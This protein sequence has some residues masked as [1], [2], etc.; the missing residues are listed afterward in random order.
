[1]NSEGKKTDLSIFSSSRS[2]LARH[3]ICYVKIYFNQDKNADKTNG[4]ASGQTRSKGLH[5]RSINRTRKHIILYQQTSNPASSCNSWPKLFGNAV[6]EYDKFLH[7]G[8]AIGSHRAPFSASNV[9]TSV[10]APNTNNATRRLMYC[11]V[12][13]FL[14]FTVFTSQLKTVTVS[15]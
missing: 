4:L 5:S 14:S 10:L 7:I 9:N 11:L 8:T 1:M 12:I 6:T 2:L 15:S 3:V 13:I